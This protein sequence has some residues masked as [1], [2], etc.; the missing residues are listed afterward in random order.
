MNQ[1]FKK[2]KV[3]GKAKKLRHKKL[4]E[5][6]PV[7]KRIYH[8]LLKKRVGL[9]KK[10]HAITKEVAPEKY[11]GS[12]FMKFTASALAFFL[13]QGVTPL[14]A[15]Q[16]FEEEGIVNIDSNENLAS[17]ALATVE[18]GFV[19][20]IA[21]QS[22]RGNRALMADVI[23]Y[24]VQ[25]GD[26]VSSIAQKFQ[27]SQKTITWNNSQ[28]NT[29]KLQPGQELLILPVDGVLHTVKSGDTLNAIAKEYSV[30]DT[31]A[32][33][34]QNK[35]EDTSLTADQKI[36]VPGGKIKEVTR[37]YIAYN[38]SDSGT[39]N[40]YNSDAQYEGTIRPGGFIKPANGIYTKTFQ[41]G[42]YAVDIANRAK[43]PI[44][45]SA[46]GVVTKAATG[47]NGGYGNMVTL[48]HPD[49]GATTLYAHM[50]EFY[51]KPGDQVT[52][53]QVIGWMGNTGRVYGATG[54]HLHFEIAIDGR[55]RN[56]ISFF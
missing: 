2:I 44:F 11:I 48:N 3:N 46:D 54:I 31:S 39:T 22:E 37:D 30:T 40:R 24:E 9:K 14:Y 1:S 53:G 5:Q 26:S 21:G 55:K 7:H 43:G 6:L 38:R 10:Q 8:N 17:G 20:T 41:A 16:N 12:F 27:I 13:I 51:V 52:Q 49:K 28:I 34:A 15:F 4:F 36:I 42:H 18:D 25:A 47:W 23:K 29:S 45:A 56:P 32:I 33:L 19:F 35:L 50:T